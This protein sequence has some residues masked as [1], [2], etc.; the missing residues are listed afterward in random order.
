MLLYQ[1]V[2]AS[3]I[4]AFRN[5]VEGGLSKRRIKQELGGYGV[6]SKYADKICLPTSQ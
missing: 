4:T 6:E 5:V 1:K 2:K 3:E